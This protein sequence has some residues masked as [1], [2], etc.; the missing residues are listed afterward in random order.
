MQTRPETPEAA[1]G[2]PVEQQLDPMNYPVPGE[3]LTSDPGNNNYENSPEIVDPQEAIDNVLQAFEKPEIQ[4]EIMSS[5]AAGMPV[6]VI[7]NGLATGGV[8]EG[9]FSPDVAEIIKP[10]IA[11][12]LIKTALEAGIPVIPFLDTAVDEEVANADL[13]ERTM[14]GMEELAP[15]RARHV[16]GKKFIDNFT[17]RAQEEEGR[18]VAREEINRR[19]EEMPM[20]SDGSFLEMEEV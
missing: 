17:E 8:A 4:N 7:V 1:Q 18:M 9:K 16:R 14:N 6:E 5:I 20:E 2:N 19:Q 12:Y 3:S 15:E 13:E 11:L 10:V